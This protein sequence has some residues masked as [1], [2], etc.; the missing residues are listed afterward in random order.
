MFNYR[1][2]LIILFASLAVS[3][4]LQFWLPFPIGLIVAVSLFIALPLLMRVIFT[5]RAS[6]RGSQSMGGS[7]FG[8]GTKPSGATVNYVCLVCNNKYKGASC[9]RCG[10]K[11]KRADF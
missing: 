1:W 4:A 8:L 7:F 2:Y 11:M 10:S 3:L 6:G 9:P 5:N